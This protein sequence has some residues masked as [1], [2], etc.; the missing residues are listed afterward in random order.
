M[1]NG[2]VLDLEVIEQLTHQYGECWGYPHAR[3]LFAL[4]GQIGEGLDY[5]RECLAY[6]VFLHDWGAYP[7]YRHEGVD[8]ALR[9]RQVAEQEILPQTGLPQPAIH[10]ILEA[11]ELH[12]YRDL[13][14]VVIP[15]ALL[16]RE[17]DCLDFLGVIGIARELA[18]GPKDLQKCCQRIRSRMDVIRG[19]LTLPESQRLSKER[20]AEMDKILG[21]LADES[22]RFL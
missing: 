7:H 19:R 16:L 5:D 4:I 2:H 1:S 9:S 3:R 15:E 13:R 18:R 10:R 22:F 17:A 6:A 11:I 20:L 14:P 8:H 12:D 21:Q